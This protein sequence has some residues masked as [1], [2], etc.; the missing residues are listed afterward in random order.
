MQH[1]L[2]L[3]FSLL[4]SKI[5]LHVMFSLQHRISLFVKMTRKFYNLSK[6]KYN[7]SKNK[8]LILVFFSPSFGSPAASVSSQESV[9]KDRKASLMNEL[10][11]AEETTSPA[12]TATKFSVTK[13]VLKTSTQRSTTPGSGKS[14]KFYEDEVKQTETRGVNHMA[15]NGI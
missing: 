7:L 6:N 4:K 10:F 13:P 1:L 2:K 15:A 5:L 8:Y 3:R 11:G 12:A 14:V 9:V